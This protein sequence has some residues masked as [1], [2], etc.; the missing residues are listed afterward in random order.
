MKKSLILLLLLATFCIN[1][2]AHGGYEWVPQGPWRI[3]TDKFDSIFADERSRTYFYENI[4]SLYPDHKYY[5]FCTGCSGGGTR[6][7]GNESRLGK[8]F[9]ADGSCSNFRYYS[10]CGL[11]S[12]GFTTT[13]NCGFMRAFPSDQDGDGIADFEDPDEQK[14]LGSICPATY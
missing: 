5:T 7:E 12:P 8:F 14:N 1:F 11:H 9:Q 4:A 3:H 6:C 10:E 2:T 13:K